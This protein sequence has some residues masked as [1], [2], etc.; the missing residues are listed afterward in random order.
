MTSPIRYANPNI[1]NKAVASHVLSTHQ[2]TLFVQKRHENNHLVRFKSGKVWLSGVVADTQAKADH[3]LATK[4]GVDPTWV[5]TYVGRRYYRRKDKLHTSPPHS[6]TYPPLEEPTDDRTPQPSRLVGTLEPTTRSFASS[7]SPGMRLKGVI[8][9]LP[10][11]RRSYDHGGVQPLCPPGLLVLV[12]VAGMPQGYSLMPLVNFGPRELLHHNFRCVDIEPEEYWQRGMELTALLKLDKPLKASKLGITTVDYG[13]SE[14]TLSF[15]QCDGG[16][17]ADGSRVGKLTVGS[18]QKDDLEHTDKSRK[19]RL[20]DGAH[21]EVVDVGGEQQRLRM[22]WLWFMLQSMACV[23]VELFYPIAQLIIN[24]QTKKHVDS[25]VGG[26]PNV[27]RIHGPGGFFC[28]DYDV[29]FRQCV[30]QF[31]LEYFVPLDLYVDEGATVLKLLALLPDGSARY[32]TA[33]PYEWLSSNQVTIFGYLPFLVLQANKSNQL[34]QPDGSVVTTETDKLVHIVPDYDPTHPEA[35]LL[36]APSEATV[37]SSMEI[38]AVA[39]KFQERP[40][41]IHRPGIRKYDWSDGW[42]IANAWQFP[43][44]WEGDPSVPRVNLRSRPMR[45]VPSGCNLM[46]QDDIEYNIRWYIDGHAFIGQEVKLLLEDLPEQGLSA[47]SNGAKGRITKWAPAAEEDEVDLFWVVVENVTPF[48][49]LG[50]GIGLEQYEAERAI[51]GAKQQHS[52]RLRI[53]V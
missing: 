19:R 39:A 50:M 14:E 24:A 15:V 18:L 6:C 36:Y 21:R 30:L 44:W 1:L 13:A 41:H 46:T 29:P 4:L 45:Q 48:K 2:S 51:A 25:M 10:G 5:G 37:V 27:G 47:E 28:V 43:H 33:Y 49:E 9:P 7:P 35:S 16:A 31:G 52:M 8:Q 12:T 42:F 34:R 17:A 23:Q 20:G 11:L 3:T 53:R 26:Q 22:E 32:T 38:V 40:T